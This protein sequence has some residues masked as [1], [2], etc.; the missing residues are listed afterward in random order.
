M[1]FAWALMAG[2]ALQV[3]EEFIASERNEREWAVRLPGGETERKPGRHSAGLQ[4]CLIWRQMAR[5]KSWRIF[6]H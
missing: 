1:Q 6:R 4:S 3:A 2:W 5:L